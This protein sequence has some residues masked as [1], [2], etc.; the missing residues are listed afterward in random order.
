MAKRGKQEQYLREVLEGILRRY[1]SQVTWNGLA[2][3]LSIDHPATIAEYLS[4]LERMDAVLI[5]PALR[6]DRLAA[7]PKKAR[8]VFFT[9]PFIMHAARAWLQPTANPF[10]DQSQPLHLFRLGASP[11][12][13]R[14]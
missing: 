14:D 5:N 12:S 9:D 6:E 10:A 3:D 11:M 13:L 4:L 7:A 8:K 1:A 2:K